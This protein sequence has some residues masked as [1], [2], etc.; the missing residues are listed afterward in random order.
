MAVVNTLK[1]NNIPC[2]QKI[3]NIVSN[4]KTGLF[5][6]YVMSH[7]TFRVCFGFIQGLALILKAL[8]Q[9][10]KSFSSVFIVCIFPCRLYMLR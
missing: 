2:F 3:F 4:I 9:A 7:Y 5:F 1:L 8:V 6:S 10:L